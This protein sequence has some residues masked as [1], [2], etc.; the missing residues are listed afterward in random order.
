MTDVGVF[1]PFRVPPFSGPES[2]KEE[3]VG[4]SR[5]SQN[6]PLCDLLAQPSYRGVTKKFQ[7]ILPS[8]TLPST[9]S[10]RPILPLMTLPSMPS[11]RLQI[12]PS[13]IRPAVQQTMAPLPLIFG[14]QIEQQE[15]S[16]QPPEEILPDISRSTM[17]PLI[18]NPSPPS[19]TLEPVMVEEWGLDWQPQI[20]PSF[21][22][23]EASRRPIKR[24]RVSATVTSDQDAEKR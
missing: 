1:A 23:S 19:T 18:S 24:R 6:R 17:L 7:P 14:G 12:L 13:Q 4:T 2:S 22:R 15:E 11:I 9:S 8:I 5:K 20:P 3:L 10:N 16:L 21:D